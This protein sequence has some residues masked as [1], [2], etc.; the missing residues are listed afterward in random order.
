MDQINKEYL[1]VQ[2]SLI[3][4]RIMAKTDKVFTCNRLKQIMMLGDFVMK[5]EIGA[6]DSVP[7][8]PGL[9]SQERGRNFKLRIAEFES[10]LEKIIEKARESQVTI[11]LEKMC[12]DLNLPS[13]A[14]TI[15]LTLF[16]A[17]FRDEEITGTDLVMIVSGDIGEL[18]KNMRLLTPDGPLLSNRLIV[19]SRDQKIFFRENGDI[20]GNTY[21]IADQ[22]FWQICG[23]KSPQPALQEQD[24]EEIPRKQYGILWIKDPEVKFEQLVLNDR[25]KRQV[26]IALWQFANLEKALETY[27]VAGKIPYGKGTIMLFYGPPGTGKT[28]TAEAIAHQLGKK[29]GYVQYDRLYSKWFGDSEKNVRHLFEEARDADCVL[30]FDEA[31]SC[32]GRRLDEF[33]STDR[34]HN[35]IT[36]ILMQEIERFRGLAILTTNREFAMD[37][38]FERRI[39]LKLEFGIPAT[40]ERVQLWRIFLGSCPLM[41]ADV[42]FEEL[43]SRYPL[44][45]GNVKNVV[46]KAVTVAA[47]ENRQITM[48]DLESAAIEEVGENKR[49]GIG[50]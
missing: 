45:G 40:E 46:I 19:P 4:A 12:Q 1:E 24:G 48:A 43:A 42:S 49:R 15:L 32:F 8:Y 25:V 18:V 21:K 17:R 28:A 22:T 9:T 2:N 11:P 7:E 23:E 31:D 33:H 10:E 20:L 5:N 39:L 38:A 16:F 26:E 30:L 35:T 14:K 37:K 3:L 36:N 13:E 50:F 27:G 34:G 47:R 44:S 6:G 29:L 41:G